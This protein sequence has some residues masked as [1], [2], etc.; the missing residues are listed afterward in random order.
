MPAFTFEKLSAPAEDGPPAAPAEKQRSALGQLLH[1]F[2][3][4]RARRSQPVPSS[5]T[6]NSTPSK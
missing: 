1:R 5:E 4:A 2:S 6:P 3:G